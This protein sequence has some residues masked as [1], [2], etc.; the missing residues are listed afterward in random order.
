MKT[1][2]KFILVVKPRN[3]DKWDFN[4]KEIQDFREGVQDYVDGKTGLVPVI[5]GDVEVELLD[6]TKLKN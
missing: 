3:G 5:V 1:K 6:V 2:K 4:D